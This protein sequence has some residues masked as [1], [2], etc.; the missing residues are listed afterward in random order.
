MAGYGVYDFSGDAGKATSAGLASPDDVAVDAM[1]NIYI[2]DSGNNCIR[3]VT[4]STGIIT[5]VAGTGSSGYNGDGGRAILSKLSYPRG[6]AV[7]GSGNF[8]IADTYANRIRVVAKGNGIITTVAGTGSIGSSGNGG[9]ATLATIYNPRT[10]AVDTS[11]NIYI[12]DSGNNLIRVITKSTGIITTVAGTGSSGTGGDGGLAT[13]A[14]L[15]YPYGV[16]VDVSGNVYIADTLSHRVR[17][18]TKSTGII[19]TIAGIGSSGSSGDGGLATTAALSYPCDVTIDASG[20]VYIADTDNYRIRMVTKST[21]TMS[22]VAGTGSNDYSGDGGQATSA[23]LYNSRGVTSDAL[24][25]IYIADAG[26]NRVRMFLHPQAATIT[27]GPSAS[28]SI[29]PSARPTGSPSPSPTES[30]SIEVTPSPTAEPS[31]PSPTLVPSPTESPSVVTPSPTAEPSLPSP[32]LDPSPTESPSIVTPS[33]TAEPSLVPKPTCA[34]S[35]LTSPTAEPSLLF[36]PTFEPTV[37]SS[38]TESPSTASPTA[39]PF[40]L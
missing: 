31:L 18:V 15:N 10:L 12:A 26:N 23:T 7:D 35:L 34:P 38:P 8:Y 13:L 32:T 21:G 11:R 14:S 36:S 17:V 2:A 5:T 33:P 40:R 29:N 20:N 22:T 9:L 39:E 28:P 30:P 37:L 19:T 6:I 25:N 24:G 3:L 1:G 27:P 4:K 16:A